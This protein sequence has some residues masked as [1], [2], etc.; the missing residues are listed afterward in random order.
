MGRQE[1][2]HISAKTLDTLSE[3]QPNERLESFYENLFGINIFLE[4]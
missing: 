1:Q 3:I 4:Y 2:C